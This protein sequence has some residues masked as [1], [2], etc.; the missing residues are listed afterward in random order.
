MSDVS[1]KILNVSKCIVA[2]IEKV[3]NVKKIDVTARV[4]K[5]LWMVCCKK[6]KRKLKINNKQKKD[7]FKGEIITWEITKSQL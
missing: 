6:N 5:I 7:K 1:A 2:V 4:A 3:E